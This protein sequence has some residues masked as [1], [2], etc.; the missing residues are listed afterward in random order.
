M[1]VCLF[2]FTLRAVPGCGTNELIIQE[3]VLST[4]AKS[5]DT[6]CLDEGLAH[7]SC[8][9]PR[10]HLEV[11]GKLGSSLSLIYNLRADLSDTG[12]LRQRTEVMQGYVNSLKLSLADSLVQTAGFSR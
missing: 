4:K 2:V 8:W 10:V 1:F 9:G 5:L 11:G 12:C 7:V 6:W 3:W